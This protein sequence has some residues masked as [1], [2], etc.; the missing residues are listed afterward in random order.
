M[1]AKVVF[2][3]DSE[4]LRLLLSIL[5]K[6]KL[7]LDCLGL[8]RV[9]EFDS[10]LVEILCCEAAILD[11]NLGLGQPSGLDAYAWLKKHEFK[12]KIIFLTGHANS[13]PDVV[14]ASELGVELLEKPLDTARLFASMRAGGLR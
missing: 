12:G 3:D 4:D 5:L 8:S 14:R 6:A 7:G 2:L 10:H 9:Q 1:P 11:I 13:D